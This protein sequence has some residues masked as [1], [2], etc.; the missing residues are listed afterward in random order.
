MRTI[1]GVFLIIVPIV[2]S[3]YMFIRSIAKGEYKTGAKKLAGVLLDVFLD[4]D[5]LFLPVILFLVVA[6]VALIL[7]I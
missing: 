5:F 3:I 7:F 1:V 4:W 2:W 6:V